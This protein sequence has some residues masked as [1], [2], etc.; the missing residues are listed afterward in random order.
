MDGHPERSPLPAAGAIWIASALLAGTAA[1]GPGGTILN[2]EQAD[3][4]SVITLVAEETGR[5]FV[6]D[7]RVDGEITVVAKRPVDDDALYEVFLSALHLHGF[8]A[9]PAP[10]AT[11]IVPRT[12]ARRDQTRVDD[13]A[14]GRYDALT[15][16][17]ALEHVAAQDVVPV[18]RALIG[19]DGHM[20]AY[21]ASNSLIISGV[22]GNVERIERLV[23]RLD[24]DTRGAA[25]VVPLKHARAA[26]VV[27]VIEATEPE[28]DQGR[29]LAVT[30]EER[31]NAVVVAGHASRRPAV[32]ALIE[33]L[34]SAPGSADGSGD[35][36]GVVY[37]RYADAEEL[38][39]LLR[40]IGRRVVEADGAGEAAAVAI[41][42][43]PGTNALVL[44]GPAP[45]VGALRRVVREL[46]IRRA[47]VLVE[48]IIVEVAQERAAELGIQWGALGSE[49]VGLVN[50]DGAGAGSLARMAGAAREGRVPEAG[51]A[52]LAAGRR[53]GATAFGVLVRALA[54]DAHSNVLATPSLLT[55][56]NTEA[57]IVVGQNVPFVTGRA[58]EDSGQA[59][60]A[61]QRQDVGVQLRVR[62]S[63]NDGDALRLEIEKEVSSLSEPIL[64]AEDLV[65]NLRTLRTT[66]MVDDRQVVVLG[67]LLDEQ[68]HENRQKIPGLGDLPG[69]GWMFRYDRTVSEKRNLMVFLRP[70]IVEDAVA[71]ARVS[72]RKYAALRGRQEAHRDRGV[73]LMEDQRSPVMRAFA[74]RSELLHL[75][76]PYDEH[77]GAGDHNPSP[78]PRPPRP[79]EEAHR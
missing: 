75:P 33:E 78:V 8:A 21:P 56:D 63:I 74:R 28:D 79:G 10:G 24:R 19:D 7:P 42:A 39:P 29:L 16:V 12:D 2:F 46:D 43:H 20:A 41:E 25:E 68:V 57:E 37:L 64:G 4:H 55:L 62:P 48:A 36:A 27:R 70:T 13:G 76:P 1:A 54:A 60:S 50:F 5:N 22:A 59:F 11:R 14:E 66:A 38:E 9:I 23:R 44:H 52:S 49:A 17:L 34:D 40:G 67:G 32:R 6:V 45:A 61:I 77:R 69:I 31:G 71:H 51:G 58:I 65:T 72:R 35:G 73:A 26:E 47:Q 30:A 15:R 18:L 53:Q 3:I